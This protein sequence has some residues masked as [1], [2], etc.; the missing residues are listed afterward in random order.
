MYKID[1]EIEINNYI[2]MDEWINREIYG[3]LDS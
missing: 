1:C 2:L 3:W